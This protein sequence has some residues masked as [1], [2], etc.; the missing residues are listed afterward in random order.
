M[1]KMRLFSRLQCCCSSNFARYALVLPVLL[2]G[3]N[4]ISGQK[5]ESLPILCGNE[6]FDHIVKNRYPDL[7]RAFRATFEE[8]QNRPVAAADRSPVTIRVVVHVV[9]KNPEENLADS[10]ILDQIAGLNEDYNRQ[11][12][13]TANLRDIFKPAA[14]NPQVTFELAEIVRVQTT[15]NFELSLLGSDLLLNLK[16]GS[17]GGS[18]ARDPAQYLNLWVCKIQP[19]TFGGLTLGQV[20]GFA[21]PPNNLGNWPADSGAP[22]L[23]Q[24]G[25]VLDFRTIGRN[26]P[27]LVENPDGSG[28][29]L[30]IRGRTATHEIGHYLGL[31]H[32]WG[33]GGV[34]GLPN[35][36][37]QSDG[38]DDTPFAGAQSA[39]DCD[40]TRNSCNKMEPHYGMDMPDLVENYMDYSSEDCMNM[41]S[42]GQ[43][44]HIQSVLAG[45]RKSLVQTSAAPL[46]V[47]GA[48]MPRL[49]PNPARAGLARLVLP[50]QW[51]SGVID[52]IGADG[53]IVQRIEPAGGSIQVE[54]QIRLDTDRLQP[55]WYA[56]RVQTAARV[57]VEQ[58]L[59]LP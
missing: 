11:N 58:L 15:A 55:G 17:Q 4:A 16:T 48:E 50:G 46:T 54:Q 9:W 37:N 33:D 57:W 12:A 22:T 43:A 10:I 24:D 7:H 53:R 25:V 56:V 6:V 5:T 39:F 14:G 30:T 26:N 19:L 3:I 27:N 36:C 47:I 44:A 38:I 18:D 40:K 29:N 23:E 45:P 31:R 20:L 1:S 13:D 28:G 41:F 21:F 32:I 59:L 49:Y 34:L 52:L 51:Q 2:F 42:Q 8:S 35:D